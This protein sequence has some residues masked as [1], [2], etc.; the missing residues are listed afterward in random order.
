MLVQEV[1]AQVLFLD[2]EE[3]SEVEAVTVAQHLLGVD[4]LFGLGL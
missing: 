4:R 3:L 1:V 2:G